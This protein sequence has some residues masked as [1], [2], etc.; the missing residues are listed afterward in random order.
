MHHP[1]KQVTTLREYTHHNS[2]FCSYLKSASC[3]LRFLLEKLIASILD[4]QCI[5]EVIYQTNMPNICWF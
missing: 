4:I 5:L 1:Y 2:D 3:I